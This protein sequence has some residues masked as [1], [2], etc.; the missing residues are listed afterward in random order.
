M[1]YFMKTFL[2]VLAL[3][4]LMAGQ[5]Q[6]DAIFLVGDGVGFPQPN[7]NWVSSTPVHAQQLIQVTN[8]KKMKGEY[9]PTRLIL[10]RFYD[11][12]F[13]RQRPNQNWPSSVEKELKKAYPKATPVLSAENR[14]NLELASVNRDKPQ[15]A[16]TYT[17]T[18]N[19]LPL[20][21]H[22]LFYEDDNVLYGIDCQRQ[23][24]LTREESV[25][26]W[27]H[28]MYQATLWPD[29]VK[30]TGSW[31]RNKPLWDP[32]GKVSP[33]TSERKEELA[34]QTE[35]L[36]VNS[37]R[38]QH[39]A[40]WFGWELTDVLYNLKQYNI[41]KRIDT[42]QLL[43]QRLESPFLMGVSDLAALRWKPSANYQPASFERYVGEFVTRNSGVPYWILSQLLYPD[44]LD[45][46]LS[47][48]KRGVEWR[49]TA[50]TRW[51]LAQFALQSGDYKKVEKLLKRSNDPDSLYMRAEAA[52]ATGQLKAAQQH[53]S[54]AFEKSPRTIRAQITQAHLLQ[55][56][57]GNYQK[58]IGIYDKLAKEFYIPS[59]IKSQ[60]YLDWG[61]WTL[62]TDKRL[63]YYDD[64]ITH[65]SE[66][67]EAHYQLGKLLFTEKK[68]PERALRHLKNYINARNRNPIQVREV[69]PM[70]K[71]L[72]TQ[73][74]PAEEEK[75]G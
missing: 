27:C 15:N 18:Q 41:E 66:N 36:Q 8:E 67:T 34:R 49:E 48:A 7:S 61:N 42:L 10:W 71:Q 23:G 20:E 32:W 51:T 72:E 68:D 14:R 44:N 45:V 31:V 16:W 4:A 19:Y 37:P 38:R 58:V 75:K 22:I 39:L 11:K 30:P 2:F 17:M 65:R 28:N 55:K 9:L 43:A 63:R 29:K 47:F 1:K 54:K 35:K 69:E 21:G 60:V 25:V 74:A 3:T 12:G 13:S 24:G 53:F 57:E 50:I 59:Y 26:V 62:E 5:A 40:E 56:Q 6:A 73:L 64:A 33:S 46:A 52:I 70:I